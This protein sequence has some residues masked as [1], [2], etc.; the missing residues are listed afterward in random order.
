MDPAIRG[1]SPASGQSLVSY[2]WYSHHRGFPAALSARRIQACTLADSNN[3]L[4]S[5]LDLPVHGPRIRAETSRVLP[6]LA[7]PVRWLE[8]VVREDS[9]PRVT[10]TGS[11]STRHSRLEYSTLV[12][13]CV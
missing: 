8:L 5:R 4:S 11:S 13:E 9:R 10:A 3:P 2:R 1:E 7:L 6:R 12:A